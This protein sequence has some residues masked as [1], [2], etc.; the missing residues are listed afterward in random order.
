MICYRYRELVNAPQRRRETLEYRLMVAACVPCV[1]IW[2]AT[3][4]VLSPL[5]AAGLLIA[6]AFW[7]RE[8][9]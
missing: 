4:L 3:F 2:L 8:V 9:E 5:I 6:P 7:S 1:F